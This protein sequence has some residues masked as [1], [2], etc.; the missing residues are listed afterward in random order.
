MQVENHKEE[1]P[2]SHYA[3]LFAQADPVEI[4]ARLDIT[5]DGSGFDVTLLGKQYRIAYRASGRA[6]CKASGYRNEECTKARLSRY[7]YV[8]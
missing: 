7:E 8:R 4:T 2:F 3:A 1:V 6:V 5:F